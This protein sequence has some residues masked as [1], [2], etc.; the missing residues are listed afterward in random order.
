[1]MEDINAG[2]EQTVSFDNF[3]VKKLG[4]AALLGDLTM[5]P[6]RIQQKS[7]R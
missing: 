3:I 4:P 2:I 7:F 5:S 1:M 6:L